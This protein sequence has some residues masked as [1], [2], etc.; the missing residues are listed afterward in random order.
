MFSLG[1]RR[2]MGKR[3]L[4]YHLGNK[5]VLI[6]VVATTTGLVVHRGSVH[7]TCRNRNRASYA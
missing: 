6:F 4:A 7:G 1:I 2:F 5:A 3:K